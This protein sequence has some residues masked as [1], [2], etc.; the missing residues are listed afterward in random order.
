MRKSKCESTT[1]G[2]CRRCQQKSL[3]CAKSSSTE[4]DWSIAAT[5]FDAAF[6]NNHEQVGTAGEALTAV[7]VEPV[8][9][10]FL[11]RLR[12]AFFLEPARNP[13]TRQANVD[14]QDARTRPS[15]SSAEINRLQ[16]AVDSLPPLDIAKFLISTQINHGTDNFFYFDQA[17]FLADLGHLYDDRGSRLRSNAGFVCL[18]LASLALGSQW[19]T[20]A[21]PRQNHASDTHRSD[22]PGR[23]FYQHAKELVP[24]L[25]DKPCFQAVQAL[26]VLGVYLMP[27]D[28]T[29]ASYMYTGMALRMA[30]ALNLHVDNSEDLTINAKEREVRRR[31]W[32]SIYSLERCTSVKLNR[33]RTIDSRFITIPTPSPLPELDR[34]QRF[35]NHQHQ[36]AYAELLRIVDRMV[37]P[38]DQPKDS[39]PSQMRSETH[40]Q[41]LKAWKASLPSSFDLAKIDPSNSNYRAVF[42]LYLQYHQAW[43]A[44]G[45][46]PL[47]TLVRALLQ[48][49]LEDQPPELWAQARRCAKSATRML[50]LFQNIKQTHNLVRFSFTDF[51]GCSIATIVI[52]LSGILEPDSS[53]GGRIAFGL[54]CLK[55]MASG[56]AAGEMG[57]CF[58]EA[59]HSIA[60]EAAEKLGRPQH[61]MTSSNSA[62]FEEGSAE[63]E[64]WTQ[65]LAGV[66]ADRGDGGEDVPKRAPQTDIGAPPMSPLDRSQSPLP[67]TFHLETAPS[68]A[69][70]S[71]TSNRSTDTIGQAANSYGHAIQDYGDFDYLAYLREEEENPLLTGLT[72]FDVLDFSGFSSL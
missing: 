68:Q 6:A 12:Q 22:I 56:H 41:A 28:A 1:N 24:D 55:G 54:D 35:D 71:L 66:H 52:L 13:R 14:T 48:G 40:A 15:V 2:I 7:P 51:H 29:S 64:R 59:L 70:D 63:Y 43:I 30:F 10:D 72:G 60:M 21:L 47:V 37:D 36:I 45:K 5:E 34:L 26:F 50:D 23:I 32:W 25:I 18:A 31:L 9:A 69:G 16:N 49:S 17:S 39:D 3:D 19:V 62:R 27:R 11:S 57:F 61:N 38:Y 58:V 46:V 65:W 20:L 8:C 42:H 44:A 67:T 33:P 53:Y 4:P